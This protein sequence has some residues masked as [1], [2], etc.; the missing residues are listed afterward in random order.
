MLHRDSN[1]INHHRRQKTS[2]KLERT[3]VRR[4]YRATGARQARLQVAGRYR[5]PNEVCRSS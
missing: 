3:L 5:E 2:V 4:I 1:T